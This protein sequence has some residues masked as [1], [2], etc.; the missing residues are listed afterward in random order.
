MFG[1]GA[2]GLRS[3]PRADQIGHRVANGSPRC[4][5]FLKSCVAG[6]NDAEMGP[7]NSLYASA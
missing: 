5:L 3:K 4:D 1:S 2:G 6:H 7:A